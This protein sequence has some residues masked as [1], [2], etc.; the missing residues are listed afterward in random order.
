MPRRAPV[1]SQYVRLDLRSQMYICRLLHVLCEC[2]AGCSERTKAYL[3]IR[4][5]I[6]DPLDEAMHR[7]EFEKESGGGVLSVAVDPMIVRDTLTSKCPK[8]ELCEV[9]AASR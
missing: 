3:E 1:W 7:T 5:Q 8:M 6:L 4:V 2:S 9:Q